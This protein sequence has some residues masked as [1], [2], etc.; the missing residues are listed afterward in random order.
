[1]A[2]AVALPGAVLVAAAFAPGALDGPQGE[3]A[4]Q[5]A[6]ALYVDS[7]RVD[8]LRSEISADRLESLRREAAGSEDPRNWYDLGSALLLTGDWEGALEPLQRVSADPGSGVT[9]E[10]GSYNF[11]VAQAVGGRPQDPPAAQGPSVEARRATLLRARDAFRRVLRL[12]PAAEDAR[13]NLEVV[14]RWLEDL[15]G[16][17]EGRG[18]GGRGGGERGPA[19]ESREMTPEEVQRLLEAA[20]SEERRVQQER[21]QDSR[22]RDPV[23]ERN[24]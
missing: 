7:L 19:G 1:M 21:F 18:D 8:S 14:E 20:G 10:G 9:D 3:G 24:W 4:A 22:N 13:W 15:G 23:A 11:G 17:G 16:G 2:V 5:E 12:D 6:P